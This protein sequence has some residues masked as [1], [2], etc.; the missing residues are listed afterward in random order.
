MT[1]INDGD[2]INDHFR[3]KGMFQAG[4]FKLFEF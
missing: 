1:G 4:R 3:Q 2:D